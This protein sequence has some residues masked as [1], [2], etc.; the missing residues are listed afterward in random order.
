M[1]TNSS[2]CP[3]C[4]TYCDQSSGTARPFQRCAACGGLINPGDADRLDT[5]VVVFFRGADGGI[6]LARYP[7]AAGTVP[8]GAN[9]GVIDAEQRVVASY[10]P[11][12][13]FQ[14]IN[15]NA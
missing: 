6:K 13:V 11:E 15:L 14:I 1:K 10:P 12:K 2:Q 3:A 4:G 5:G 7:E 9:I 8:V